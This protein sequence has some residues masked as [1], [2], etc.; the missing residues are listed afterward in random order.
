MDFIEK[1]QEISQ[2]IPKQ[3]EHI[4]TEEAT[5]SAFVMPFVQALG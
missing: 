1:I 3:I 5:K 4:Q 2:R